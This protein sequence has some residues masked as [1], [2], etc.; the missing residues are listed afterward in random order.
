M[1][2]MR[3]VSVAPTGLAPDTTDPG[4]RTPLRFVLHPW[5]PSRAPSV[6]PLHT[7]TTT[8]YTKI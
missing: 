2:T 7:A 5:L 6:R 1:R 3:F 4:V 8:K